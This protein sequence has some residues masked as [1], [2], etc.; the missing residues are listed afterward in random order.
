MTEPLTTA[1]RI[2]GVILILL[3]GLHVP[4]GRRLKWHEEAR[5]LSP[6]N[7]TIFHVHTFFICFVLVM[8]GLPCLLEPSVLLEKSHAGTWLAWSFAAFWATRLVV[9]WFV[10]SASLWRGKRM[11][12]AAHICFSILWVALSTL[13]ALCGAWQA[14]WIQ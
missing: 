14:G 7:E 4:I 13:F 3:A 9:Q 10:F 6:A 8:M 2:A 12:T 1:V 11:E 5:R